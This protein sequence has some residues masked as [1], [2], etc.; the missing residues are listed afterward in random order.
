[1]A[2]RS[3]PGKHLGKNLI[4]PAKGGEAFQWQKS[5]QVELF[6]QNFNESTKICPRLFG[7]LRENGPMKREDL[8]KLA[9]SK[10]IGM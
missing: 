6:P 5:V 1:M 8:K 9:I 3:L 2:Y 7:I 10:G 4:K